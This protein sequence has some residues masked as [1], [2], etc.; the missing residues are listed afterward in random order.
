M[1]T[2]TTIFPR[3]DQRHYSISVAVVVDYSV[4]VVVA[5]ADVAVVLQRSYLQHWPFLR[6]ILVK[7]RPLLCSF[8]WLLFSLERD[9]DA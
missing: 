1:M 9:L 3:T 8:V 2:S 5:A 7:L 6:G 4:A